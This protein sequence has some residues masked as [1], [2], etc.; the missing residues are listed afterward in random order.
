MWVRLPAAGSGG[1]CGVQPLFLTNVSRIGAR[2][3]WA[4]FVADAVHADVR[5]RRVPPLQPLRSRAG[6]DRDGAE[7]RRPGAGQGVA[8]RAAVAE[9]RRRTCWV[10]STQSPSSICLRMSS[11]KVTSWPPELPQ[12]LPMPCGATKIVLLFACARSP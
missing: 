11:V 4:A 9:A 7:D 12:P 3:R 5:D 2:W 1:F 8:H 10:V 6:V